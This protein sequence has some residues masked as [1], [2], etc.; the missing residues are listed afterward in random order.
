MRKTSLALIAV[1]AAAAPVA[2]WAAPAAKPAADAA[3]A[4]EPQTFL[5]QR[6]K[7]LK[8]EDFSD[9]GHLKDKKLWNIYKGDF[10]VQD[11]A[12][13]SVER[14]ED[15]HHPAMSTKL[16]A[17]DLVMQ[18]RFKVDASKW[19]GLSLDNGKEKIH[20]FRAMINPNGVSLK[21]MTGM[22]PT[23]K[24]ETIAEKKFKFEPGKWYTLVVE[25]RGKEAALTVPEANIA[26]A[27]E[28][29]G[30]AMEKDRFELIS[31]G[32]AAWFDDIKIYDATE[33]ADWAKNKAKFAVGVEQKPAGK[34]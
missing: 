11:G 21:R 5:T 4:K 31:G 1:L 26:I 29:E 3:G 14:K 32:D 6:G 22:G 13:R 7:L 19:M 15:M 28:H 17:K 9:A 18:C 8:E 33:N 30:V 12:L 24:G 25:I 10:S 16:P 27:G 20:V 34:K 23:T 2:S